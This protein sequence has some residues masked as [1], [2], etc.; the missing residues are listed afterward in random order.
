MLFVSF[1]FLLEESWDYEQ[2]LTYTADSFYIKKW[3]YKSGK[4]MPFIC[5]KS[6]AFLH[7][8]KSINL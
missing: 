7:K 1:N 2:H 8:R 4:Y 6:M 3:I 5:K